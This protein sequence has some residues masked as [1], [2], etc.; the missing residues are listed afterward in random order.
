MKLF[1]NLKNK[2]IIFFRKFR[3]KGIHYIN[4]AQMLPAPLN[5]DEENEIM[6]NI[7]NGVKDAGI[8][9]AKTVAQTAISVIGEWS[10]IP[11]LP[12]KSFSS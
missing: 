7:R 3:K 12:T 6:E 4:G 11:V 5:K 2:L 9:A 1:L 10:K 8:R